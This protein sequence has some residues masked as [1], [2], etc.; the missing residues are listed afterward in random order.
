MNQCDLCK[1]NTAQVPEVERCSSVL[2]PRGCSL[3][4]RA[5]VPTKKAIAIHGDNVVISQERYEQL[6]RSEVTAIPQVKSADDALL[7]DTA[8]LLGYATFEP[9]AKQL[10]RD[11]TNFFIPAGNL[12][13]RLCH[14]LGVEPYATETFEYAQAAVSYMETT[15]E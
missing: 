14:R 15:K 5:S 4:S 6:L 9:N 7:R 1:Y 10:G 2:K 8:R 3:F 12:Y 11:F 13:G